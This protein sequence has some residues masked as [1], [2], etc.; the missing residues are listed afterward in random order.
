MV[1]NAGGKQQTLRIE[2][3]LAGE[4]HLNDPVLVGIGSVVLRDGAGPAKHRD[5]R[6]ILLPRDVA[7]EGPAYA[8]ARNRGR[9]GSIVIFDDAEVWR[10]G[11]TGRQVSPTALLIR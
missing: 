11:R 8:T 2:R 1:H 9:F 4:H 10:S 6:W 3:L 5:D 7:G